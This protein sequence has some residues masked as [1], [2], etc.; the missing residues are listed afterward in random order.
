MNGD[1]YEPNRMVTRMTS[2][3]AARMACEP[4]IP[5]DIGADLRRA[6]EHLDSLA[7]RMQGEQV[8]R[9]RELAGR[10]RALAGAIGEELRV[11]REWSAEGRVAPASMDCIN[12]EVVRAKR[13][14]LW[15][16]GLSARPWFRNMLSA[17]D[18]F[19]GYAS[20]VLPE[21]ESAIASGDPASTGGALGRY[22]EIADRFEPFAQRI[23]GAKEPPDLGSGL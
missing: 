7:E 12:A 3:V 15:D 14:W 18:E 20:W 5:L 10:Y 17:P 6:A 22:S 23:S 11:C 21:L 16:E 2:L 9:A 1:D 4:V 8:E 19:S 13:A